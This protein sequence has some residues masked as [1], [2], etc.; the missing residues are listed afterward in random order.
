MTRTRITDPLTGEGCI[1]IRSEGAPELRIMEQP[2]FH[3][4][5]AQLGVRCGSVG[6]RYRKNGQIYTVPAGTAHF[7]E[8]KMFD[9]PAGDMA[10]QFARLGASENAFTAF[11]RTVYYFSAQQN[12]P[13]ALRL[14]PALVQTPYFLPDSVDRERLIIAQEIQ[15]Y[16]LDSPEDRVFFQLLEGLYHAHP[17]RGD[18]A[19]SLSSITEITPE[20]LYQLHRD[21]YRPENMVLCCAGNLTE[22]QVLEAASGLHCDTSEPLPEVLLPEE[23]EAPRLPLIRSEMDVGKTQFALGFK[24]AP[25][26]GT[27]LLRQTLLGELVLDLLAGPSS[28]FYRSMLSQGLINDTFAT[29]AFTGSSWFALIA[30]GESDEPERVREAFF[31]AAADACRNG[32]DEQRFAELK[33]AAYGDAVLSC[34]SPGACAEAM[35]DAAMWEISSPF[36][37]TALLP[38]LTPEDACRCIAQRLLPAQSCLSVID[39]SPAE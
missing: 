30:E 7:L 36:A 4:V 15:E 23:P 3:T 25:V 20:L 17:V 2:G 31:A 39:P 6:C 12:I 9:S 24:S 8:H 35:L 27:E 33:A 14:L 16:S 32:I 29:S 28:P 37:R 18:V 10:V 38:A 11:D 13:Q 22:E 19:G 26:Q 5:S 1:C 21:F 34:N